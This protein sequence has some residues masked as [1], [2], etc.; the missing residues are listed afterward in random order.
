[1]LLGNMPAIFRGRLILGL[2]CLVRSLMFCGVRSVCEEGLIQVVLV[3]LFCAVC[4]PL[5]R[6]ESPFGWRSSMMSNNPFGEHA[7]PFDGS[8]L[9]VVYW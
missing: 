8:T 3:C 5:V 7:L 2:V 9:V 1:M 6:M 4:V